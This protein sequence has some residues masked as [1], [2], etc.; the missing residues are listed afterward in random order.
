VGF[1][2]E[3]AS[4]AYVQATIDAVVALMI[5]KKEA[6]ENLEAILDVKGVDMVQFGPSDYSVSIGVAG[7]RWTHPQVR[8][9]EEYVIKTALRKGIAPRAEINQ[10]EDAERYL[11]LGVKHFCMNNDV[12][13]LTQFFDEKGG[14]LKQLLGR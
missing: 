11:K 8:E 13:I 5:E 4:E 12:R 1:G 10:P 9:A 2:R 7:Q 14:A 6:V 3:T